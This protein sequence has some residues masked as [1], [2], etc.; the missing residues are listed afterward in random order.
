MNKSNP[1]ERE[2]AVNPLSHQLSTVWV[3]GKGNLGRGLVICSTNDRLWNAKFDGKDLEGN[4]LRSFLHAMLS[5]SNESDFTN[6]SYSSLR[7]K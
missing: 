1:L 6:L 3:A 2:T 5:V 7:I 4:Y